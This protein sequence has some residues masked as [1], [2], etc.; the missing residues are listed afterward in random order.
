MKLNS[1][2][3]LDVYRKAS[4]LAMRIFQLSRSFPLRRSLRLPDKLAGFRVRSILICEKPGPKTRSK[5]REQ[6]HPIVMERIV[7]RSHH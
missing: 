5:L 7:K 6:A 3:E 2:E 4:K 1:A